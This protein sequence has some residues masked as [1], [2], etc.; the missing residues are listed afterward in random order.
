MLLADYDYRK[1]LPADRFQ[2]I[3][4]PEPWL[5]P[6]RGHHQEWLHAAK[7][8]EPTLCNFDYSGKLVEHNLLGVVAFR[9]QSQLEWDPGALRATNCPAADAFIRREY[10]DGW[11]LEG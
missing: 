4:T 9:A 3:A 5:P 6:S 7:T 11:V 2:D 10:R 8:G 1:L